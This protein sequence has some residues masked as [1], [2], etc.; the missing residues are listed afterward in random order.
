MTNSSARSWTGAP[1]RERIIALVWPMSPSV[2]AAVTGALTLLL[3]TTVSGMLRWYPAA[4]YQFSYGLRES[5]WLAVPLVAALGG[6]YGDQ[7]REGSLTFGPTSGRGQTD[8]AQRLV[9]GLTVVVVTSV[10]LTLAT[11]V[12]VAIVRGASDSVPLLDLLASA[13]AVWAAGPLGLLLGRRAPYGAWP[14]VAPLGATVVFLVP[15]FIDYTLVNTGYTATL[16]SLNWG[17][18]LPDAGWAIPAN[19]AVIR[20][21]FYLALGVVAVHLVPAAPSAAGR[22][23]QAGAAVFVPA[24][25]LSVIGL[26]PRL[27]LVE[28]SADEPWCRDLDG[29]RLCLTSE[30]ANLGDAL[31]HTLEPMTRIAPGSGVVLVEHALASAD[32]DTRIQQPWQFSNQDAYLQSAVYDLATAL[33]FEN[34]CEASADVVFE[35]EGE[36]AHGENYLVRNRLVAATGVP[37]RVAGVLEETGELVQD[38]ELGELATLS[39][40]EFALWYAEHLG[41][42]RACRVEVRGL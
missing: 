6:Y 16:I 22:L 1:V 31:A 42:I 20:A 35:G 11:A 36:D 29:V 24:I 12:A 23:R 27:E 32:S 4:W 9:V 25:A 30:H 28:H 5:A 40:A 34:S 3:L 37:F 15:S 7:F 21:A 39:D 41:E 8:I 13:A 2:A 18:R 26:S 33:A 19:V 17:L 14:F 10:A 38:D